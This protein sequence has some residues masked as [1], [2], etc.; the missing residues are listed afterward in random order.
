VVVGVVGNGLCNDAFRNS[1]HLL[2]PKS[3]AKAKY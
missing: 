1:G 2:P 3:F